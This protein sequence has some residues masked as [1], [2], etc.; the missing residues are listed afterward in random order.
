MN[1]QL[2]KTA[3]KVGAIALITLPI[4]THP[5]IAQLSRTTQ[6]N[7]NI[8]RSLTGQWVMASIDPDPKVRQKNGK[9]GISVTQN[10][11]LLRIQPQIG[12]PLLGQLSGQ[13]VRVSFSPSQYI[14][15]DI[16]NDANRVFLTASGSSQPTAILIRVGSSGCPDRGNWTSTLSSCTVSQQ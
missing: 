8:P 9:Y 11:N 7:I 4:T 2:A 12:I 6:S 13:Q 16:S 1:L 15:G 14:L 3:I 5:T 10:G